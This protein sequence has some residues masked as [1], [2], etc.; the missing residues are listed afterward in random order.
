MVGIV[1]ITETDFRR[2]IEFKEKCD[3]MRRETEDIKMTKDTSKSK[4]YNIRNKKNT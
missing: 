2:A 4:K 1:E 3:I